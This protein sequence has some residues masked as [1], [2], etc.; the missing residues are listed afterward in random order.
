M[1][2]LQNGKL[3]KQQVDK[4]ES[5]Q[6]V[7][8]VGKLAKWQDVKLAK[9]QFGQMSSCRNDAAPASDGGNAIPPK[10]STQ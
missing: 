4:K 10:Q 2:S 6:N 3:A 8:L 5:G 7:K 9:W 1:A